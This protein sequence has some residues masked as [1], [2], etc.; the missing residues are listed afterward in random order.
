MPEAL[1]RPPPAAKPHISIVVPTYNRRRKLEICLGHI[2]AIEC[3]LPWEL[4]VV[5]N[6][7]TD[8]TAACLEE[9]AKRSGIFTRVVREPHAGG[10]R[11]RNT[12]ARLARGDL[13]VFIDDD[14]YA[15]RD[16]LDQYWRIFQNDPSLGFA[17]G[18]VQLYDRAAFRLGVTDSDEPVYFP[19]GTPVPCGI[20]QGGNLAI[21]KCALEAVH[22]FDERMG[23]ALLFPAEDWEILT[24]LGANG[25]CGGYFPG[26]SVLHDHGKTRKQARER[27]RAYNMGSGAVYLKLIANPKTRRIYLAHIARRILGDMKFRQTK[28]AGQAYGAI[29]FLFRYHGALI[30]EQPM[31]LDPAST[32]DVS[33]G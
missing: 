4:I 7:S 25:W 22:G 14:C 18:R 29:R 27:I 30:G 9:F 6:G 2:R 8:G 19:A 28:I 23:P 33:L 31:L 5:D 10:A 32:E 21:R 26:P 11:T 17:G 15:Q 1:V 13:L 16:I 3:E 24:R 12:G 20:F